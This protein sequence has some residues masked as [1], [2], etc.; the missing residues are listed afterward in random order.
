MKSKKEKV[1]FINSI[2]TKIVMMVLVICVVICV[3]SMLISRSL[4][5]KALEDLGGDFIISVAE[6]TAD[7]VSSYMNTLGKAPEEMN[8]E[9]LDTI[10]G[11]IHIEGVESSFVYMIDEN[12]N[13]IY[14]TDPSK[15]G[16]VMNTALAQNL[17]SQLKSGAMIDS[18]TAMVKE[19]NKNYIAAYS[20]V[21]GAKIVIVAAAED[22]ELLKSVGKMESSMLTAAIILTIIG[23]V[24]GF[25]VSR[26]ICGPLEKL[27]DIIINT[28]SLDFTHSDLLIAMGNKK[29]EI[30]LMSREMRKM[31]MALRE[32][33][34]EIDDT[35][36]AITDNMAALNEAIH[37]VDAMCTDNSATSEELAAGM[38]ETAATTTTI[39]ENLADIKEEAR[40]INQITTNGKNTAGEVMK[41]ANALKANTEQ[42][43]NTTS[44]MYAQVQE[45]SQVAIEN[46]KAVEKINDLTQTINKISSQTSLLALNASIEAARAGEAGKGFA[47]VATEIGELAKQ[48]SAAIADI[49]NIVAEVNDAVADMAGCLED[50]TGFLE[51]TVKPQYDE[52][53]EVS[54]QYEKDASIFES[55]MTKIYDAMSELNSAIE[56]ISD[57]VHEISSTVEESS[58][59]VVSIAGA[60]TEMSQKCNETLDLA[61]DSVNNAGT[62]TSIVRRFVVGSN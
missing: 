32:I 47:V 42:A 52:F 61:K 50:T 9:E 2:S 41:R 6:E 37:T 12:Q 7:V 19:N 34:V 20:Q 8:E 30:G 28:A 60:T 26:F 40:Q 31:R 21:S 1:S 45:R 15:E 11:V 48:T 16:T 59:G 25:V 39:N 62:L 36:T 49:N 38:Q 43:I 54:L 18:Q 27:I 13:I 4:A 55:G 3:A 35:E 46:S 53:K 44:E 5:T 22:E 17:A 29:D 10:A 58:Q 24:I 23:L 14:H 51:G 57:S 33:V 56:T